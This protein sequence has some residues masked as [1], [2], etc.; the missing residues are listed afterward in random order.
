M[1]TIHSSPVTS[2]PRPSGPTLKSTNPATGEVLGEVPIHTAEEVRQ[3]VAR[4]RAAQESWGLLS[5]T[6]RCRRLGWFKEALVTRA[7]ELSD[8]IARENGKPRFEALTN[9]VL[10]VAVIATYYTKNGPAIL[11]PHE[12]DLQLFKQKKAYVHRPPLGVVGILSPWNMPLSIA[13]C[14]TFAALIAGNAVVVKP[15]E[16]TPLVVLR[17]KEIYDAA[18]L[19][20]DLFQ[21][22]TGGPQTGAAL[23][24][25]GVDKIVFTGSVAGGRKVGAACGERL[26]PCTLELGGKAAAIVCDDADLERAARAIVWGGFANN[27][28]VCVGVERVLAHESI[29]DRLAERVVELAS[30]IRQGDPTTDEIDVGAITFPRQIEVAERLIA[31]AVAKGATVRV[32]GKRPSRP[33]QFFEPTVLTGC[34]EDMAVMREEIFGPVVP[35]L[36]VADEREAIRI[37]NDSPLGLAGYVF[38]K[39]R[40][41]GLRLAEQ[42]RAGCV[43]VNDVLTGFAIPEAPFG[44]VKTS[45]VGRVHGKEGLLAMT[46]TRVVSYERFGAFEK[47]PTWFPYS[48]KAYRLALKAGRLMFGPGGIFERIGSALG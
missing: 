4:A 46:E 18:G 7:E 27:G 36:K 17:A 43:Q 48:N 30:R 3:A 14:D 2:A 26:I 12:L 13:M 5:V 38:T 47:D 35:I 33:G 22:V 24:D 9:E 32:G 23:V 39:N 37:A 10:V 11:A 21:V 28:Q 41:R 8:L 42:V 40:E 25:G 45:G 1:E 20:P 31:D 19:P 16:V 44:G 34:T 6:E 29:H 15:S